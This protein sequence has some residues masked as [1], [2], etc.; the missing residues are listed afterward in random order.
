MKLREGGDGFDWLLLAMAYH[1]L[2]KANEADKWLDKALDW[3][4]QMEQGKATNPRLQM[5]WQSQRRE[6]EIVRQEAEEG[7]GRLGRNRV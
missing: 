3:I 6:A 2:G 4:A 7:L 5:Q 1:Q